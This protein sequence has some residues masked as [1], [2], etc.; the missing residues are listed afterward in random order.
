MCI[1]PLPTKPDS[2]CPALFSLTV[3]LWEVL[4]ICVGARAGFKIIA[5]AAG[6]PSLSDQ[7]LVNKI[8]TPIPQTKQHFEIL[9]GLRGV[10][11][12]VIVLGIYSQYCLRIRAS[13]DCPQLP[14]PA[15]RTFRDRALLCR[16][17]F[18]QV[19]RRVEWTYLLG[20]SRPRLVFLFG[21]I[22]YSTFQLD[23]PKQA[24]I[25]R[26]EHTTVAGLRNAVFQLELVIR[27]FGGTV[28]FSLADSLRRGDYLS[29]S[30][31]RDLRVFGEDFLPV[32]HDALCSAV[33][34]R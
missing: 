5:S 1:F 23:H 28:L 9:D 22:A 32:I 12:L 21:R 14:A 11:A 29:T 33:D 2:N 13:S 34:L 26:S 30:I 8:I 27:T 15:D 6:Q 25:Y 7:T 3:L 10:A 24:W 4:R 20:R 16:L 19:T 18:G 17:P 31:K